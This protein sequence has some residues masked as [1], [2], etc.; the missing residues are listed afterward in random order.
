ML[1]DAWVIN[2]KTL[3]NRVVFQ[4]MEGCDCEKDG[5]PSDLTREKYVKAAK[6]AAGMIWFEACAVCPEGRTNPRQM[7]LT[8][9]NKDV[10]RAFLFELRALA[11]E[12]CGKE[13]VMILQLTH[14][15]RQ[16]MRPIIA[17]RNPVYEATRPLSDDNLVSDEYL[18]TL[19]EKYAAAAR[20]AHEV[21]F[22]G[23]D[24]KCCHGYL[25]QETLSAYTRKGRYGGSF[26]NRSRLFLACFR[27]V[28]D[29]VPEDFLL[30]SRFG[31]SD[32]I[33]KP[34]GFGT[35]ECNNMDLTEAGQIVKT[36][37]DC[38]LDALNVT[39]GNPYYNPHVN[40]PFR[41]GAYPPPESAEAGLYRFETAEKF[42][43][44][45]FP[46]LTLLSSGLSYY[47]GDIFE[48]SERLLTEGV[49]DLV[50]YGRETLAYPAFYSDYLAG[51]FDARRCCMACSKC[52]EL[53]RHKCVAGCAVFNPYY[54]ELYKR[55]VLHEQ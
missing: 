22:D 35:D 15:G 4:P 36:L 26:E 54:R 9:E 5:S 41:K 19:P 31:V 20:L 47:R 42:F 23:V 10:F 52:T 45:R 37:V 44:E 13:P 6:S 16:S 7:R 3:A 43:K 11:R 25:L 53:M 21:G 18:D 32:M 34:F 55:C 50:G 8:G 33:P 49:C 30:T 48:Q 39:L 12:T 17:Y 38:G 14:S 2:G 1:N 51:K 40:R 27:A 29:A 28:R 24:V 46:S